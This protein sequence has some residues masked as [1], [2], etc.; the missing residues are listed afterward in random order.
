[1]AGKL[2]RGLLNFS[3]NPPSLRDTLAGNTTSTGE[4][5]TWDGSAG[6]FYLSQG[7]GPGSAT[8]LPFPVVTTPQGFSRRDGTRVAGAVVWDPADYAGTTTTVQ[9]LLASTGDH[10]VRVR[11]W[12]VAGATYVAGAAITT[13][14]LAPTI[15]S[16]QAVSL[17]TGSR[18]YEFHLDVPGSGDPDQG[19]VLSYLGLR[20]V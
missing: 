3:G 18:A 19:G 10:T 9:V 4:V 20:K 7:G 16:S 17:T 11:A 13:D 12:D 2:R 5:L 1:M 6:A 14:A 8:A 15:L